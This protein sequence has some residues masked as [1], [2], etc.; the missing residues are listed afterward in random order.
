MPGVS[1]NPAAGENCFELAPE[2]GF[3][4]DKLSVLAQPRLQ[5]QCKFRLLGSVGVQA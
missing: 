4:L 2:G 5:L 3:H 1:L